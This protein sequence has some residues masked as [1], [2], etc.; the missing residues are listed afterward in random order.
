MWC[1]IFGHGDKTCPKKLQL[2]KVWVP[3]VVE[4]K[5]ED[6]TVNKMENVQ[7]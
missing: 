4:K 7:Q 2:V 5:N 6:P 3:K 1:G